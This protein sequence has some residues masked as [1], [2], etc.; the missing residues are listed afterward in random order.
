M[1]S[2]N[3]KKN[4]LF[5]ID[6]KISGQVLSIPVYEGENHEELVKRF[7]E[8]HIFKS[9][10]REAVKDRI[11]DALMQTVKKAEISAALK[12]KVTNFLTINNNSSKSK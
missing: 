2:S 1:L 4:A 9:E 11:I 5:T 8:Q 10:Y 6:I 3:R 7:C 12:K